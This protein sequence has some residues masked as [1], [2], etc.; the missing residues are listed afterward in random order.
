MAAGIDR[1]HVLRHPVFAA[2]KA[3]RGVKDWSH[4]IPGQAD[5]SRSTGQRDLS[6]IFITS[7]DEAR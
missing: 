4:L 7:P 6:L 2:I 1:W 5:L 3:D